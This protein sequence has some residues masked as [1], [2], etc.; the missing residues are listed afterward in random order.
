[1]D[2]VTCTVGYDGSGFFGKLPAGQEIAATVLTWAAVLLVCSAM[3]TVIYL[4]F[5]HV[6]YM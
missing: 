2:P 1:M 5:C 4:M 6:V 3:F